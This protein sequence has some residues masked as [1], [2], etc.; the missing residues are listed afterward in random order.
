MMGAFV[1][2]IEEVKLKTRLQG[3]PFLLK[4]LL[5][6]AIY[7]SLITILLFISTYTLNAIN[8]DTNLSEDAVQETVKG[9]FHNFAFWSLMIFGGAMISLALFF[10][11]IVDYLGID[12]V[13]SF[14]TGKYYTPNTENRVFMFLDMK[15]STTIA[16][17]LG[18][19]KHYAFMNAY[20]KDMSEAIVETGGQIYQYVG[21]EI[22]ISWKSENSLENAECLRCFFLINQKILDRKDYYIAQFG[23]SPE[24]RAGLHVGEVTRGQIG[25][26]KKE[27]LYIGDVLNATSRIQSKCKELNSDLLI[28]EM[29][30]GLIKSRS[31]E[32]EDMGLQVLR[33]KEESIRLFSVGL[34]LKT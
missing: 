25:Q 28:S 2:W 5:K 4:I 22:V 7:V 18:H 26:I 32:F 11:E 1:G 23:M 30:K 12:V 10:S 9:F 24:F 31:Y 13:T 34:S 20:F 19:V 3:M 29:L 17:K 21:D 15:H 33:G 8:L 16:E 14:F 27:M 6:T